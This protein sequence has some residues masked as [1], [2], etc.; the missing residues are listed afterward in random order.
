MNKNTHL[1]IIGFDEIVVNK[2]LC[3]VNEAIKKGVINGYSIIDLQKEKETVEKRI[4]KAEIKPKM[5]YYLS[6]PK[7]ISEE[8]A[9]KELDGVINN[10]RKENE[11]IKIY[12]ATELKYHERYLKYCV[13]N[14]IS[15]LVEKPVFLP[16]K[17]GKFAPEDFENKMKYYVKKAKENKCDVSVMTLSRYHQIYTDVVYKMIKEKLLKYQAPITSLHIK[18]AGGVW[19]L[20]K[21]YLSREDHPYK[22]G[23]GMLMHG[24]YHYVDMLVQYLLLNKLIYPEK[25]FEIAI[26]SYAAYPKD[27][28]DRISKIASEKL[29]DN[30]PDWWKKEGKDI[31]FGET[32]ITSTYCLRDKNTK[33]VLTLGTIA[34]EQTT[35]SVRTWIDIPEGLY[36]KN[37]RTSNV[38]LEIQLSTLFA[39]SVKCYKVPKNDGKPVERLPIK[40]HIITRANAALLPDEEYE[41]KKVYPE[42]YNSDSN[43]K[44]LSNW[45]QGEENRSTLEQHLPVIKMMGA[46]GM[47]LK[48]QGESVVIDF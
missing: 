7:T 21:E 45:L 23:Y 11:E 37:G 48:K 22:Y 25:Q 29:N 32:D 39:A 3:I 28:N 20:H 34:L 44:I 6:N 9:I 47:S 2:Y 31:D 30:C 36:N 14:G 35:P 10:I 26:T 19:N 38:D 43:K 13:E 16:L 17:D 15:C 18:H 8:I 40:P 24:A 5:T 27:Q 1:V 46:I 41:T 4:K 33:R 12:I 42:V